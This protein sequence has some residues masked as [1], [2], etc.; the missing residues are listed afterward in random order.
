MGDEFTVYDFDPRS[1]PQELLAAIGLMTACAAQ[2]ESVVEMAIQGFLGID[3]EYGM[4]VTT[5]MAMPLRFSALKASGEIR[6]DDLDALD[7]L[8]EIVSDLEK[9]FALRNAVVHHTWCID[10]KTGDL[11]TVRSSART[12]VKSELIPMTVENVKRDS[13]FVYE[14]GMR[15]MEFIRDLG[16]LPPE[17]PAD[18][19]RWHKTASARKKRREDILRVEPNKKK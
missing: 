11:F 7:A 3:F 15:L 8:D 13:L 4:A 19:Y 14:V 5:H 12:S 16:L 17:P 1:L 6:I 2:T 10:P 18:R 9:A